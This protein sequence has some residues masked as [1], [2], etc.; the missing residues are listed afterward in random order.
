MRDDTHSATQRLLTLGQFPG[1]AG[2]ELGELAMIADNT[3][4]HVF[5]AGAT[6]EAPTGRMPGIHLVVEGRV[7]TQTPAGSVAAWGPRSVLGALEVMAGRPIAAPAVAVVPTRT[8]RLSP[9]DFGEVLEDNFNLLT[10]LRVRIA[11]QLIAL[12]DVH[13]QIDVGARGQLQWTGNVPPGAL[14]MV[15]RLIL[16]R[17]QV[18]FATSKIQALAALAQAAE[19]R[20]WDAG[21]T[22]VTAGARAEGATVILDGAA[23]ATRPNLEPRVLGPGNA[24]G[25]IETI[26]DVAQTLTVEALSPVRA[27]HCPGRVLFDVIEDHTD[28][29]MAM[30]ATLASQLLDA[31]AALDPQMAQWS[32]S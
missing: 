22:I 18:P 9:A 5:P 4:E 2:T 29:G 27:L 23:L 24:V 12:A 32:V 3:V 31:A 10:Q 25:R 17:P 7:V 20:H 28:L 19:E 14:G 8:L 16:I 13:H 11:R 30:L 15:D 1:L 6:V 21:E 26:A